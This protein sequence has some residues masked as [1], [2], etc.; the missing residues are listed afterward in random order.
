MNGRPQM[1][2]LSAESLLTESS[3]SKSRMPIEEP[4]EMGGI[5]EPQF[6]SYFFYLEVGTETQHSFGFQ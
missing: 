1:F 5:F 3:G 6:S 4:Y 2:I